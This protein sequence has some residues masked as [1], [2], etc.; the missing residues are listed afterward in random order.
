MD[1]H[2]TT[3]AALFDSLEQ[4]GAGYAVIRL[5]ANDHEPPGRLVLI[6]DGDDAAELSELIERWETGRQLE[7]AA[8]REDGGHG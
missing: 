5:A 3:L 4:W 6:A 1:A 2:E 7:P 8:T